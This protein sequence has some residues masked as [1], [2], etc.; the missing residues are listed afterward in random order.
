MPLQIDPNHINT[1]IIDDPNYVQQV[2]LLLSRL[3]IDVTAIIY[4][5]TDKHELMTRQKLFLH[6]LFTILKPYDINNKVSPIETK[7]IV[8]YTKAIYDGRDGR[9]DILYKLITYPIAGSKADLALVQKQLTTF[10]DT[11]QVAFRLVPATATPTYQSINM[12]NFAQD[13]LTELFDIVMKSSQRTIMAHE[14]LT[15]NLKTFDDH[16]SYMSQMPVVSE[17]VS[18][19]LSNQISF[20]YKT[21]C[22]ELQQ[23]LRNMFRN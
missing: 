19:T 17:T 16:Y 4:S 10:I 23:I 8:T 15:L 2:S 3:N 1:K 7:M 18:P 5:K 6:D 14:I 13:T 9:S 20:A 21:A 22:Q 12:E 11:N